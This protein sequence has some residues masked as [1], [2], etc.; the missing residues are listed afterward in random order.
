MDAA[1]GCENRSFLILSNKVELERPYRIW[2]RDS[3]IT[4]VDGTL[5]MIVTNAKC[6]FLTDSVI[7]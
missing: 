3:E 1:R 7:V 2:R 4:V 6:T 5:H